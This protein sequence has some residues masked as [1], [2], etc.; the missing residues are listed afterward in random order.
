MR[1]DGVLT[2]SYENGDPCGDGNFRKSSVITFYCDPKKPKVG[3]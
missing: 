3:S 2:L 1:A